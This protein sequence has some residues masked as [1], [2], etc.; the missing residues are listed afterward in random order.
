MIVDDEPGIARGLARI[1]RSAHDVV[2]FTDSR[3]ALAA[4]A[5]GQRFDAILCDLMMPDVTGMELHA[6][7]TKLPREQVDR[8]VFITGGAFTPSGK[9]FLH[10]VPN[11]RVEKPFDAGTVRALVRALVR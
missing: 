11:A 3:Q 5:S 4:I 2:I 7:L 9:Q 1:L 6:A 8:M 10:S